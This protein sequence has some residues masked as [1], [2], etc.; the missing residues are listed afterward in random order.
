MFRGEVSSVQLNLAGSKSGSQVLKR[1]SE[2]ETKKECTDT[3]PLV[4]HRLRNLLLRNKERVKIIDTYRKT[5]EAI[6]KSFEEIKEESGV[7]DL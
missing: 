3:Q 2:A 7:S 1:K 6:C 4:K 5:M